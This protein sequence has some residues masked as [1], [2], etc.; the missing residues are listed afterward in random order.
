MCRLPHSTGHDRPA[1]APPRAVSRR[2]GSSATDEAA[3]S[4]KLRQPRL[5]QSDRGFQSA[6]RLVQERRTSNFE[7]PELAGADLPRM[8][9]PIADSP[10]D[11]GM[12]L[13]AMPAP[14]S[15]S[16]LRVVAVV[17]VPESSAGS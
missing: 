11:Q 13:T 10:I 5:E 1:G 8:R 3:S 17:R 15:P 6:N 7:P 9:S 12:I 16:G 2:A 4:R 14:R